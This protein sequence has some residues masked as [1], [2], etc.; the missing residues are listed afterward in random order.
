MK[1][2]AY[3]HEPTELARPLAAEDLRC[4]NFIAVLEEIFEYPS[5]L[6]CADPHV[7]P[8]REPV[9]VRWRS[10]DAGRPLKIKAIC[11]PYVLVKMPHGAHKSLDVR[12]CRL[13][14]LSDRYAKK[15]WKNL[16]KVH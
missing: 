5:Y 14:R 8:P 1:T 10:P 16:T 3:T 11:F 6:W 7:L 2:L 13:V 4:G 15:A 9:C 12:Q